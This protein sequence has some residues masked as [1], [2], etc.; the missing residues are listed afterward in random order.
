MSKEQFRNQ[1]I[2]AGH[3]VEVGEEHLDVNGE[4]VLTVMYRSK[5]FVESATV[6]DFE[7]SKKGKR[8]NK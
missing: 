7:L 6:E 4:T 5:D 1:Q 3:T 8:K 2:N